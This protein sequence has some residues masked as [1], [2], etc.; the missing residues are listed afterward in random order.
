MP[1]SHLWSLG[2]EEQ[3]YLFLPIFLYLI[4]KFKILKKNLKQILLFIF[5]LSFIYVNFDFY[6]LPF[7]C[8]TSNC[9]EVTNFYWLHTRVWELLVGTLL[10]FINLKSLSKK[11]SKTLLSFGTLI[12]F[13]SFLFE[14]DKFNHPGIKTL[15]TILGTFLAILFTKKFDDNFISRNKFLYILG[16]ISYSTYLIH[17]P[18]FAI[19]NYY[20]FKLNIFQRI[21]IFPY[22]LILFSTIIGYFMWKYIENAFRNQNRYFSQKN[23]KI[24]FIISF[25]LTLLLSVI[26]N[27]KENELEKNFVYDTDFQIKRE[28][29]FETKTVSENISKCLVLQENKINILII[30]SSL[31]QNLYKG[32]SINSDYNTSYIAIPGCPP[33][34]INYNYEIDNFNEEFCISLYKQ[35][36]NE[37]KYKQFYK[38]F[39]VYDWSQL[40]FDTRFKSLSYFIEINEII[41]ESDFN[42]EIVIIGQP[43]SWNNQLKIL[44]S[45][46]ANLFGN[47]I[48]EYNS[49]YLNENLFQSENLTKQKSEQFNLNYFSLIDLFCKEEKCKVYDFI[50][51]KYY[52]ISPDY[53]HI[54]DY[55]SLKISKE[56]IKFLNN[57]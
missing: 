9:I 21:D 23:T 48:N 47:F 20:Q 2:I 10:N 35:L 45:R 34:I 53:Q 17:F 5:F 1:F 50:D 55:F 49:H 33:L 52:F 37:L 3:F 4:F 40:N 57:S 18:L 24:V 42:Q 46:E 15:P 56:I 44:V 8:P 13:T 39:V 12:I 51:G 38:I 30:G 28:C 6:H 11:L 25:V 36:L 43:V 41:N 22:V 31:S 19:R 26:P 54:T 29:F 16:K 14:L 27:K 32:M 7:D